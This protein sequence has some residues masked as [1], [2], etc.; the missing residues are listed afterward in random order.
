M[1][2]EVLLLNADS[3]PVSWLPLSAI[4]WQNAVRLIWLDLVVV[5]HTYDHWVV[6]S[7]STSITV[8]SV[9]MLRKQ[10]IGF[11]RWSLRHDAPVPPHLLFL[12]DGYRCQYCGDMFP[13]EQL[14]M[15]HVLPKKYGGGETWRNLVC[16]CSACNNRRGHNRRIQPKTPPF[17]PTYDYL[18][19]MMRQFPIHMPNAAWN[20]YLGWSTELVTIVS[21]PAS[22]N[23]G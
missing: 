4:S 11:R 18:I 22:R 13:R 23:C 2:S 17:Y 19:K 15:D 14:T 9:L 8:P 10:V 6:R 12:R 21:P 20:I 1:G 5:L 7:P 16:A 3:S